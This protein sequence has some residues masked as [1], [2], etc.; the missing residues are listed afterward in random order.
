M[1]K[2]V[3]QIAEELQVAPAKVRTLIAP[4]DI[5][6]RRFPDDLRKLYYSP[7]DIARI[8]E[9]QGLVCRARSAPPLDEQS[10]IASCART[11]AAE[12]IVTRLAYRECGRH[13]SRRRIHRIPQRPAR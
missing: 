12:A 1:A 7:E 8:K 6:P 9:A 10:V 5:Q 11:P 13:Q 3:D 2:S 4:L